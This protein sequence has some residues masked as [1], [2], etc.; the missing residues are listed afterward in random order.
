MASGAAICEPGP[1]V[2]N[3]SGPQLVKAQATNHLASVSLRLGACCVLGQASA[4]SL[5]ARRKDL[6]GRRK[7]SYQEVERHWGDKK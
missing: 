2:K 1:V 5:H 6:R 3:W 4:T 7:V